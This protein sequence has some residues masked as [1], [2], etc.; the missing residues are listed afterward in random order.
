MQLSVVIV[1][2]NVRHFLE[3]CLDSVFAALS[4]IDAEVIV[5]D[6]ASADDSCEMIAE[7]FPEAVVIANTDN[8]GFS[9]A[10]NQGVAQAKGKFICILNPDTVVGEKTFENLLDWW[11]ANSHYNPGAV[12][13]QLIDGSGTFLPESKRQLPTSKVAFNKFFGN[14]RKYYAS[15]IAKDEEGPVSILVGAFMFMKKEVYLEVGGFDERYFM[16]G[17]DIDLSYAIEQ[18]GYTNYYLGSE[19]VIHFK[20][21]STA[22]DAK[23]RKR[24]FGAMQLFYNKHFGGGLLQNIVLSIGVRLTSLSKGAIKEQQPIEAKGYALVTSNDDLANNVKKGL[25]TEIFVTADEIDGTKGIEI[26]YDASCTSYDTII[27][28]LEAYTDKGFTYKFIPKN[29]TFAIGSNTSNHRGEVLH[30]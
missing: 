3:L 9:K 1:N 20:G 14:G 13:V 11:D 26:I 21:E 15:H 16:Y 12:G 24:F 7:R 22:K 29:S 6:N 18:A 23:Y 10:N 19:K 17:E 25:G 30:F 27:N 4:S 28:Q 8:V 5:I 2:Y